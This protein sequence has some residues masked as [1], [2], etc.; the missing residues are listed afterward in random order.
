MKYNL[1][2]GEYVDKKTLIL[3]SAAALGGILVPALFY[4]VFNYDQPTSKGWA[5]TIAS[6]TAFM[7]AILAFFKQHVSLKLR[8]F[9]IAF[10]LIDD[11]LA[12]IILAVFYSKAINLTAL[13]VSLFF[14][15][16]LLL[17]NYLNV[18]KTFYY[19]AIGV[20]LWVSMVESGIHGTLSG[21]IVALAI[22]IKIND[23]VNDNY[24]LLEE[25]LRPLVHYFILPLFVC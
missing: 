22:P 18:R 10:S 4:I 6:D 15:A 3:P 8:A 13:S 23:K 24:Q 20:A 1:V 25:A 5:I 17:L 2:M 11:A 21:V 9:I 14:V 19:I 12:L 7:L 16:I